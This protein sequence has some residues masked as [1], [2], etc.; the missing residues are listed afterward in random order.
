MA[1]QPLIFPPR[2]PTRGNPYIEN[3]AGKIKIDPLAAC[4][5]VLGQVEQVLSLILNGNRG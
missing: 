2:P 5:K 3:Y 1:I 4:S